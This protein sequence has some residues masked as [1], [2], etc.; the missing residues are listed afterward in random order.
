MLIMSSLG[1]PARV[2]PGIWGR[3]MC[4][5]AWS[6]AVL[7]TV[8]LASLASA[9]PN[10]NAQPLS[11]Q[12]VARPFAAHLIGSTNPGQRMTLL[13]NLRRQRD[14]L[15]DFAASV[16]DPASPNY[17]HFRTV[18]DIAR[19]FG[20]SPQT[21]EA[22]RRWF[23]ARGITV[24]IDTTASFATADIDART[25]TELFG[26]DVGDYVDAAGHRFA[27]ATG[28]LTVPPGLSGLIT[29]IGGLDN[30]PVASDAGPTDPPF[31]SPN[32]P[33]WATRSGTPD[34]AN[35]PGGNASSGF[36]PDQLATAFGIAGTGLS[37]T[38][39]NVA[40]LEIGESVVPSDIDTFADCFHLPRPNL[41][42]TS[43][44]GIPPVDCA[45]M[46]G[47]CAEA[48]I[49]T[50]VLAAVA[51]GASR[52]N[53]M[54]TGAPFTDLSQMGPALSK[55]L[56]PS[57]TGGSPVTVVSISFGGCE[58]VWTA[59]DM[60]SV[61]SALETAAGAGVT[62]VAATGDSGSSVC[63]QAGAGTAASVQ[64]PASSPWVT[65]VGGTNLQLDATNAIIDSGVFNDW[66][67][68]YDTGPTCPSPP[69]ACAVTPMPT[70]GGGGGLSGSNA[71]SF[72]GFPQ[73]SWQQRDGIAADVRTVPDI[74]LLADSPTYALYCTVC[75]G[76]GWWADAGT[77]AAAPY[78]AGMVALVNQKLGTHVGFLDPLLYQ[79][80]GDP[81]AHAFRDVTAGDNIVSVGCGSA[82]VCSPTPPQLALD[83]CVAGPGYDLATGWGSPMFGPFE[84]AVAD[85]LEPAVTPT[86]VVVAPT[87]SPVAA[88]P[89]FT[90]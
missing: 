60:D 88:S 85:A 66:P 42:I 4:R 73:P 35:C 55:T 21:Q 71:G 75:G 59:P 14:D 78:F 83:C 58:A 30:R 62:V 24:N 74:A 63:L 69:T 8:V 25:A 20:A 3:P 13:V 40:V 82:S 44:D 1:A 16:S 81:G 57:K 77:S 52:L 47:L 15:A 45:P 31:Y 33:A 7:V 23:A 80:G 67:L 22:L 5:W 18:A 53:V 56:D 37:G 89:S 26:A 43:T 39:Q 54:T 86:S 61:Q 79:I 27:A 9:G 84:A 87:P 32:W 70:T 17:R 76:S 46:P 50:E 48:N 90:G 12:R 6:R 19:Q 10:V 51:P 41:H 64:F 11:R 68:Q 36:T 49:D 28:D 34:S 72:S 29:S 65:A 2:L 38:G